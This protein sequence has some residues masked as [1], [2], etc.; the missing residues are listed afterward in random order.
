MNNVVDKI[1]TI[2][3]IGLGLL[4]GSIGRAIKE[5]I[6]HLHI[7][8]YDNHKASIDR[9]LDIGFIDQAADTLQNA[10]TQADLVMI[11]A[12]LGVF[13]DI[14]Q[15]I[16]PNMKQGAIL[17]D[18]GSVKEA[19]INAV[20][21]FLSLNPHIHFVPAHPIAGTEKSGVDSGF[22][23]LFQ[24]RMLVITPLPNT[25]QVAIDHVQNFWQSI[26]CQKPQLMTPK[27]HDLVFAIVS[28]IPHL[29]AYNI[30]GTANH[31]EQVSEQEVVRYAASGFRDFTRLAS[32]DPTIWRDVFLNNREAVLE[33]LGRFTE[34]L[35]NLQRA[36]RYGDGDALFNLFSETRDIRQKIIEAGQESAPDNFGRK[37]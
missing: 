9:A 5:Y 30:V 36:I 6:P 26:G 37:Q 11:A 12:P 15:N 27:H 13:A 33:M 29:I 19:V 22:A 8:G 16:I 34:D 7:I 21:P 4:G 23:A 20:M 32:S 18:T 24:N 3:I 17:T 10:V 28:H 31:L 1:N 25:H 14:A 35:V 2:A